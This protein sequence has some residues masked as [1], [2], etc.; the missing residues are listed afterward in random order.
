MAFN[1]FPTPVG[2]SN[3]ILKRQIITNSG[4]WSKPSGMLGTIVWVTMIGGGGSGNVNATAT[5]LMGGDGG[6]YIVNYAVDIGASSSVSVT[7]GAGGN[8]IVNPGVTTD[9]NSGSPT[10]FGAFVTVQGGG[11]GFADLLPTG[12]AGGRRN[13]SGASIYAQS[14]PGVYGGCGG[15]SN[16]NFSGGHG[17]GGLVL[18]S[19]TIR[20]GDGAGGALA[21]VGGTGYGAGGGSSANA[22]T[23][24]AGAGA[25]GVLMV[26]W[27][28]EIV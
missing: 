23:A 20:G 2:G 10:S 14:V 16:R 3:T 7:I 26:E 24:S 28:E 19:T 12:G 4:T 8:T 11:G 1:I 5:N 27:L 22:L 25:D 21:G 9:G 17:G 18:N 6:Q 13:T 15:I